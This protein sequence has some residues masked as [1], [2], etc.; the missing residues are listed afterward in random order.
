MHHSV[1]QIGIERQGFSE[2]RNEAK[3]FNADDFFKHAQEN[4]SKYSLIE[5]G[6]DLLVSTWYS[7]ELIK[8]Y[9]TK[10]DLTN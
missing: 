4:K 3:P 10:K 7:D 1:K 5:C 6:S 9:E 8:S 2:K